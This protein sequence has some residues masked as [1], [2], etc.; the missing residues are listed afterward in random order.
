MKHS[1]ISAAGKHA[2]PVCQGLFWTA[3]FRQAPG[4]VSAEPGVSHRCETQ[5]GCSILNPEG[6]NRSV[7]MGGIS[8]IDLNKSHS[9]LEDNLPPPIGANSCPCHGS[10]YTF[11]SSSDQSFLFIILILIMICCFH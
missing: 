4:W 2:A 9:L 7:L 3:W 6:P 10:V 11:G 5:T 8:V 1:L